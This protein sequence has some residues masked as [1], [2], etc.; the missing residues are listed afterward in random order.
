MPGALA[1]RR[2]VVIH[3]CNGPETTNHPRVVGFYLRFG[4]RVF[5]C[6]F[7]RPQAGLKGE[8][9]DA[10]SD[11]LRLQLKATRSSWRLPAHLTRKNPC[12]SSPHFR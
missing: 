8:G 5:R 7:E 12:S 2:T 11:P 3:E 1:A 6:E 4:F 10:R 9:Q